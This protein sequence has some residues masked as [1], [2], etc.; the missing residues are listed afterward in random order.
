M[1]LC[2]NFHFLASLSITANR[3]TSEYSRALAA[4]LWSGHT[5]ILHVSPSATGMVGYAALVLW[6]PKKLVAILLFDEVP[7]CPMLQWTAAE[8]AALLLGWLQQCCIL[9]DTVADSPTKVDHS[10]HISIKHT[11]KS[12]C[13]SQL[14]HFQFPVLWSSPVI[15]PFYYK[16]SNVIKIVEISVYSRLTQWTALS[17][18]K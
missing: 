16:C 10:L 7:W 14:F 1:F 11:C 3:G 2:M 13:S 8:L 9:R 5:C 4:I 18:T 6:Y 12:T 17:F 15:M